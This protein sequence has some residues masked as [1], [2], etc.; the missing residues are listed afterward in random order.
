[1][2]LGMLTLAAVIVVSPLNA[3]AKETLW[4]VPEVNSGLFQIGVAHG[5]RKNCDQIDANKFRGATYAWSLVGHA[6]DAGYS[7]KE[8]R[9]FIDDKDEKAV[10]RKRVVA[11]YESKGLDHETP[12]GL[13]EYGKAQIAK[14][15]Q[16][17]TLLRMN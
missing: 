17:G 9:A 11:Y 4:D 12:N 10:L 7:M 16:V 3:M 6:Q 13:C 1:M 2:K 8:T 15:S 5:I 14:K